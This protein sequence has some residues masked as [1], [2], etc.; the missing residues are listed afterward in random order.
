MV[1]AGARRV[2][3]NEGQ[4]VAVADLDHV[5][6]RVVKEDL[7]S[8]KSSQAGILETAARRPCQDLCHATRGTARD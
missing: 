1:A 8:R 7:W 2:K 4:A 3:R 6:V 5:V